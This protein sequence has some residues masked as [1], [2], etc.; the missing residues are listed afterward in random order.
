MGRALFAIGQLKAL[1]DTLSLPAATRAQVARVVADLMAADV[2]PG[3]DDLV[4]ALPWELPDFRLAHVRRVPGQNVWVWY[5]YKEREDA[6]TIVAITK[7]P[8]TS[9]I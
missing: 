4:T 1:L 9:R 7:V 6:L 5:L 2:L 8:P 3:R